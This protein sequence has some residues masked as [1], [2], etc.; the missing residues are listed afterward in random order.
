[1]DPVFGFNPLAAFQ[2]QQSQ[3]QARKLQEQ[4]AALQRSQSYASAQ[5]LKAKQRDERISLYAREF[6][7]QGPH[8]TP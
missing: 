8:Q 1:M 3:E 2:A 5:H 7:Y 4:V 6:E